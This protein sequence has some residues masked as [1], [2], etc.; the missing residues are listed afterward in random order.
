MG[1]SHSPK[2]VT[3]GLILALDA[4]NTKSYPGS[5]T[6]WYDLSGNG[7]NGTIVGSVSHSSD[8]GGVF[9]FPG[10]SGNH[11]NVPS[12]NLSNT[13]YTIMGAARKITNTDGR[14]FSGLNNNWL[15]G[16][17]RQSTVRYYAQGWVTNEFPLDEESDTNWRLYAATGN[18]SADSWAF[19]V[20][21]QLKSGP[22][23][24]GSNGP[25]GFGLGR[26]AQGN[27]EYSNS[28]ISFL[29]AYNRVLTAA[30]IEQ[31]HNALR[32]R[33]GI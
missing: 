14:T 28:Q 33:F 23:T 2:I 17:W 4:G 20:N 21:G 7:N 26:W 11:I 6:T 10:S 31:N 1:L 32:G 9:V 8:Y 3:D 12:P 22:N 24:N 16:H 27:T 15:M 30:E 13:N 19:Y 18:Y 29:F 5:G 25:N